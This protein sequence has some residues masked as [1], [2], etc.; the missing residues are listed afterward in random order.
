MMMMSLLTKM[1]S[2]TKIISAKVTLVYLLLV[3]A[4]LIVLKYSALAGWGRSRSSL[5]RF[6]DI[7]D[8][9]QGVFFNSSSQFSVP[10]RKTLG[11]Q[12]EMQFHEILDVQKILVG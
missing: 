5:I 6:R 10:K 1:I 11:S 8:I 9:I 4:S 7:S 2:I 3:S 12:S